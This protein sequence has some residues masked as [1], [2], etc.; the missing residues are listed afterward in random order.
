M[1]ITFDTMTGKFKEITGTKDM[2]KENGF[3]VN[4][5]KN[6]AKYVVADTVTNSWLHIVDGNSKVGESVINFNFPI[7]YTCKHDCECYKNKACYACHGCY[8]FSDNQ[9]AYTENYNFYKSVPKPLFVAAL[10]SAINKFNLPLMRYFTI[11]DIPDAAFLDCMVIIAK[12]NPCMRFWSYTKK[13]SIVN[14]YIRKHGELPENL[15]IIFSH[16]LNDNG[17]YYPMENP[18]NLP[19]SDFIPFGKEQLAE[20]VTHI[21]PCSDPT[22]KATCATC[23]KPCY[24]LAHGESMALL[25]HST[26][27]TK[28]RDKALR[29]AH[30]KLEKAGK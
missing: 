13:Y 27:R 5:G 1:T 11:G 10:Q 3:C 6:G 21:C 15:V 28:E 14:N 18:Y 16:W 29:L 2:R 30:E 20:K 24:K 23:E 4:V 17:T 8:T 22:V 25:E 9:A 19:T 7:E 12:H 26:K